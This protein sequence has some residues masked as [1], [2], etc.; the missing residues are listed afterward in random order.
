MGITY[1]SI[2][3][4]IKLGY[5]LDSF[6]F[7]FPIFSIASFKNKKEKNSLILYTTIVYT[8]KK[9]LWE[10]YNAMVGYS[11]ENVDQHSSHFQILT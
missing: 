10:Y 7:S 3:F 5:V 1:H 6:D 4:I 2:Y 11:L 9:F 8:Y